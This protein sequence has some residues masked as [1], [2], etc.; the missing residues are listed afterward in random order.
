MTWPDHG[1]NDFLFHAM[2][3]YSFAI[4]YFSFCHGSPYDHLKDLSLISYRAQN[5]EVQSESE[6]Y[7]IIYF[8]YTHTHE[9][10]NLHIHTMGMDVMVILGFLLF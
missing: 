6:L 5:R 2:L 10:P 9:Q 1:F 8:I 4:L 7:F 3:L